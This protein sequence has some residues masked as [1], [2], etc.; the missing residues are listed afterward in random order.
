[1]YTTTNI[2]VDVLK[3]HPRNTEFFDDIQ[4][5]AYENFKDSIQ[6][7]GILSPLIAAPDMT[8]ISGHQR[9]KAARE[10]G[11]KTVPVDIRDDIQSDDEKLELLLV[12]NFGREK[13]DEAKRRKV[14]V[15]YVRLK[16]NGMGRPSKVCDNRRL[17][18]KEIANELGTNERTLYE[19]LDIE[20]RLTP[21]LKEILDAGGVNK[22][23]AS[24]ILV[25]L[26][27]EEQRSLLEELGREQL[28]AMTQKQMQEY[29]NKING[30]EDKVKEYEERG[31]EESTD[32]TELIEAKQEALKTA[33]DQYERAERLK[34][35]KEEKERE[36]ERLKN[37]EPNEVEVEVVPDDYEYIKGRIGELV[38]ENQEITRK[39]EGLQRQIK[40]KE[41][42]DKEMQIGASLPPVRHNLDEFN[43]ICVEFETAI[44]PYLY[45]EVMYSEL[46]PIEQT[47]YLKTISSVMESI[48]TIQKSIEGARKWKVAR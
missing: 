28:A 18:M 20:K 6:R 11:L 21:E 30:L 32:V 29:I 45:M 10:I 24:K 12:A 16:S 42:S 7:N 22:T 48:T 36:I 26:S 40:E 14:A 19:L 27:P 2:S 46:S 5:S 23:T 31:T 17:S 25:K 43:S 47:E 13:N 1:M 39:Y 33:R 38:N 41:I 8:L 37:Q 3:V 35:E 34:K 15:E 9:L 44:N 4:G